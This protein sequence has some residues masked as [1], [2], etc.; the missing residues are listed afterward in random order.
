[1]TDLELY[2]SILK[3]CDVRGIDFSEKI[4]V[5]YNSY[6]TMTAPSA[7]VT[8]KWV[9]AVI[10]TWKMAHDPDLMCIDCLIN[11]NGFGEGFLF[12]KDCDEK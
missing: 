10:E 2:K 9:K 1:M 5:S 12:C 7:K 8:P 3:T 4:G 11:E 6:R